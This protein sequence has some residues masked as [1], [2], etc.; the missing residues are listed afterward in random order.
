ME[1]RVLFILKIIEKSYK[2][3]ERKDLFMEILYLKIYFNCV[4]KLNPAFES[5]IR[6]IKSLIIPLW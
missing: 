1:E 5:S 3:T 2:H 6:S 4:L